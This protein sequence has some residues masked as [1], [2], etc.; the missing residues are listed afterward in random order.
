MKTKT[1]VGLLVIAGACT[2]G[3]A[4]DLGS[5]VL[6]VSNRSGNAQIHVMNAD[7][8][9][10]RALTT[11]AH[12]NTEPAWS[13]DG[14]RIAFTSYRDGN[15]EI[16]VMDA[17]GSHVRRLTTEPQADNAP[18]W[19]PDGR[20]VFRSVRNRW[21]NFYAMNADGSNVKALTSS[22]QD[23]GPPTLSPDGRWLAF[24]AHSEKGIAE[25]MVMPAIGGEA[26]N[27]TGQLSKNPKS[28]PSWSPDSKRLAY[29][30]SKGTALNVKVIDVDGS[31]SDSLTDNVYSNASPVWSPDGKRIAFVSSRE[32]TRS[33]MARGEI[34]VM[35][36]DGSGTT[37]LT[38]HPDED[39]YPAWSTDGRSIY[40]VS[41]RSGN[42]QIYSVAPDGGAARRLTQSGGSDVMV[43]P[44]PPHAGT[45][46][47]AQAHMASASSKQQ[48]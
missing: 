14:K 28:F 13:P 27:L 36:A 21:A 8:S 7:G 32:G 29:L 33:D 40:F 22:A 4:A 10:D 42:A 37:N 47:V 26:R 24:V 15:G 23:K 6:F 2:L 20:I 39:N 43:R 35:N 12:E 41:L 11:T 5:Q 45:G 16:Y 9:G 44:Q 1:L 17:D 48:P 18:S 38:H 19:T 25:I 46:T 30:E 3:M 31:H 34:Y